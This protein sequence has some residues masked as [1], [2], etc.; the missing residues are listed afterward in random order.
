MFGIGLLLMAIG[1]IMGL[2]S[3]NKAV[4]GTMK[5]ISACWLCYGGIFI[6]LLGAVLIGRA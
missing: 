6:A 4:H 3:I 1:W 2:V 5:P